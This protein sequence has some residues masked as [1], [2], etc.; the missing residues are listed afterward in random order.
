[1][2]APPSL[3]KT[4]LM[5]ILVNNAGM[6]RLRRSPEMT[7]A[8]YDAVTDAERCAQGPIS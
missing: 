8:D 4:A 6:N 1:M 2:R 7:P 5:D 3:Q